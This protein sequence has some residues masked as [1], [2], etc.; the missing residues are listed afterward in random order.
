M[1]MSTDVTGFVS[2]NNETYKK[3]CKVLR[4]CIDAGISELPKETAEYFNSKY[5]SES[6]FENK[7]SVDIVAKEWQNNSSSGFEIK[8]SEI[9]EGV[10]KIRFYNSW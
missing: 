1:G 5:P 7:L 4:A 9:P 6:L 10:D 8:V 2:P 3:H